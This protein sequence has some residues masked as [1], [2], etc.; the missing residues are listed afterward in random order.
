MALIVKSFTFVQCSECHQNIKLEVGKDI[1]GFKCECKQATEIVEE[2][3]KK[4]TIRRKVEAEAD[5][6]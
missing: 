3:P 2:A 6:T 4:R 5:A 1:E